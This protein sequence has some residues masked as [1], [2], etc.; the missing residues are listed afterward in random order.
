MRVSSLGCPSA[1][2]HSRECGEEE[3][4]AGFACAVAYGRYFVSNPDL[5]HRFLL[6]APLNEYDPSTFVTPGLEGYND[7]PTLEE[8]Q[9][10]T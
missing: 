1:C 4:S 10:Q 5:V 6:D 9:K 7:Y 2:S 8:Q 3:L